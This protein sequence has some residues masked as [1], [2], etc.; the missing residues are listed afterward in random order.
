MRL[1]RR[2]PDLF[3]ISI[4][5]GLPRVAGAPED[6]ARD[7]RSRALAKS[8]GVVYVGAYVRRKPRKL[9]RAA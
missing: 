7:I 2:E 3:D 8:Y 1:S 5:L 4:T 9:K 6:V